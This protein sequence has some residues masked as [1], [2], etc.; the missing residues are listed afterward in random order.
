MNPPSEQVVR[1]GDGVRLCTWRAGHGPPVVLCHG[2]PGLWD[3]LEPVA[4]M[5][6][7]IATVIR[8]DQRGAGRS[9][10]VGPYA[11]ARF[12]ADPEAI[13]RHVGVDRWIIAGHSWG[14][15]LALRYGLA[16][17]DRTREL[18]CISG[19][20]LDW[21]T[22]RVTYHERRLT[23]LGPHRRRWQE[24]RA[25]E[26]R[27]TAEE[28]ELN[29]LSWSTDF[30]GPG[31]RLNLLPGGLPTAS[32]SIMNATRPSQGNQGRGSREVRRS[33]PTAW[34]PCPNRAR[35]GRP[36]PDHWPNRACSNA[37]RWPARGPEG[38]R[39]SPLGRTSASPEGRSPEVRPRADRWVK[40]PTPY[41]RAE[42]PQS[43]VQFRSTP[44]HALPTS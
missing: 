5:L 42:P 30:A 35:R 23:R 31:T 40:P 11:V 28:R 41:L 43:A 27:T 20:D 36:A 24:L 9:D 37:P 34:F 14:E 8:W 29:L 3:E 33:V 2:G 16:H 22:H 1:A 26:N 18:I 39:A 21:A 7:D 44:P 12:V 10:P 15:S 19:T 17:P 25:L 38:R 4:A 6:T 13:R 32:R